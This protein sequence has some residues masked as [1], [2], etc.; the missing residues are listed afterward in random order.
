MIRPSR[1][2]FMKIIKCE[3]PYCGA[4]L[5]ENTEDRQYI[6]C[7]YC[8]QK[9]YVDNENREFRI[10]KTIN[11]NINIHKD[12]H[13]RYTDDADVIRN[14]ASFN[15]KK[16]KVIAYVIVALLVFGA[17]FIMLANIH[18]HDRISQSKGLINAGYYQDL[19]NEDY[20]TVEAHFLAA[21]FTNIEL[22]DLNDSGLAFWKKDKVESISV[23]GN[24]SFGS[25]DWFEPDTVVVISY[26]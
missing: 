8:G 7:S 10:H 11:Q 9:L 16:L 15:Y 24:R 20:K 3:C 25:E 6:F 5:E 19:L 4:S 21:G 12:V 17:P 22:I 26:H 14:T 13:F 1:G 18:I 23:G 2:V